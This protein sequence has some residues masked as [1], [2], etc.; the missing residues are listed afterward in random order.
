MGRCSVGHS[1][2]NTTSAYVATGMDA[3]TATSGWDEYQVLA[4]V[5][6]APSATAN[7]RSIG[8]N[9]GNLHPPGTASVPLGSTTVTFS[10]ALP[11]PTA[12]GAVGVGD[13]LT[14]EGEILFIVSRD[15]DFQV[16]LQSPATVD[17]TTPTAT[18]TITRAYN[19]LQAWEDPCAATPCLALSGGVGEG[20]W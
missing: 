16:T 12:V 6:L 17:H 11:A 5:S 7:H 9:T 15:S 10:A 3:P 20:T 18:F 1:I 13:N 4:V 19:T 14:I 2:G 8:T